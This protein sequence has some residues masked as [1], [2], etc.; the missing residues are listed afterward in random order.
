MQEQSQTLSYSGPIFDGD[1]HLYETEDAWS[2][3][4]PKQYEKDWRYHFEVEDGHRVLYIGPRKVEVSAGYYAPDGKVPAP[5]KLHEWLRAMKQGKSEIDLRV[6]KTADM[7]APAPR[8][9]KM[10]EFG[11]EACFIY[12]G[13]MV[14]TISYLD[15]LEPAK[16]VIHAYN[17]WMLDQWQ[18]NYRDRI[19]SAPI[20]A[21]DDLDWACQEAAWA[22]KNGTRLFLMPMGPFNGKAPAHPDHDRFWSILNEADCRVVFHVSEAIYMK[23]HMAVWGER[24]QASRLK[25][26]AFV[27]MH[28][29][30]ERPVIE[31]LSSFIFY[32]FF[33]RF[34][35][36]KLL[37]AENGAEW[38]PNMLVKMDK[39]RGMAKTGHWPCG[40]L[41]ERPSQIFKRHIGVVAY[42]EDDLHGIIA[43]CNGDAGWMIMGSDY[44]HSEGVERPID[45]VKEGCAGLTLEQIRGV[46]YDNGRNF[47][48]TPG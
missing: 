5:G 9:A 4:L 38:V 27:W 17:Q 35:K 41:E 43:A 33:A 20:V 42:P 45:F 6:E 39:V 46:M 13:D 18:F 23:D 47:L 8:L 24:M 40:Q 11:V 32:N 29:Y 22:I 2:R 1:T 19:Y 26:T 14:A 25:Q 44:P 3:Y 21:L 48:R 15:Q 7:V 36:V 28:G 30:S 12:C 37:S 10:D 16:A 31:T 34:P